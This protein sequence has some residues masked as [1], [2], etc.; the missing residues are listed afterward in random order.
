[1]I[2]VGVIRDQRWIVEAVTWE[3]APGHHWVVL[4]SNGAGKSTVVTIAAGRLFPSRGSVW[5]AGQRL[6]TV[7]IADVFSSVGYVSAGEA[8]LIPGSES[9]TDVILTAAHGI[10]GRWRETYDDD[11]TQ[12]AR[13]LLVAVGMEELAERSFSTLSDGERQR[14]LIARARMTDPELLVLDEPSAGLDVAA[15]ERLLGDLERIGRDARGPSTITVTHHLEE[16]PAS[17]THALLLRDGRVLA[18]GPVDQVLANSVIS[19]TYGL[20]LRVSTHHGRWAV[21]RR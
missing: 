18:Q 10:R 20:P 16:I 1:M 5:I 7:H 12:R 8:A 14:V 17:T 19:E 2:D 11:D 15:R 9:V 21:S 4:G 13:E 3:V 6:G